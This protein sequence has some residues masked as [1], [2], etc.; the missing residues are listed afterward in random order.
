MLIPSLAITSPLLLDFFIRSVHLS[1]LVTLNQRIRWRLLN[2]DVLLRHAPT[3]D[4]MITPLRNFYFWQHW[5]KLC[6]FYVVMWFDVFKFSHLA[7]FFDRI[8]LGFMCFMWLC[9]FMCL[10]FHIWRTSL[11]TYFTLACFVL[12]IYVGWI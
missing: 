10:N 1:F 4:R 5:T 3:C 8:G 11:F 12:F 7:Y 9:D 2:P 6:V